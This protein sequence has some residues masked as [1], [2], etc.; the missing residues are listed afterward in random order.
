MDRGLA[1]PRR[2]EP[3]TVIHADWGVNPAKRIAA[4]ARPALDG[5]WQVGPTYPVGRTGSCLERLGFDGRRIGN[6]LVGFDFPIGLPSAYAS[7]ASIDSFRD[8]LPRFGVGEWRDFYEVSRAPDEISLRRPFFPQSCRTKGE[9]TWKHLEAGLQL[10]KADL[11]RRCELRT[12]HK[13]P[14]SPLFWT[15]GAKQVGKGAISGWQEFIA[16]MLADGAALWPFDGE[17]PELLSASSCV[18]AETYPAEFYVLLGLRFLPGKGNGKTIQIARR[19]FAPDLLHNADALGVQLTGP[20]R[21]EIEDGFDAGRDGE[22][23]FDAMVGL[24]GMLTHLTEASSGELLP[25]PQIRAIEG[26]MLGQTANVSA[27]ARQVL[28]RA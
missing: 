2:V 5:G 8:A 19:R 25:E 23:R 17:L 28:R 24:L 6:V 20:A 14:A 9:C 13:G 4:V 7:A 22:D 21:A 26:W 16:P 27:E 11:Y 18:I 12:E 10:T 1:Q 15:L 3:T